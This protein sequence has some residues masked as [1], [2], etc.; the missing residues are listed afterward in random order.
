MSLQRC[1][2]WA[3][4]SKSAKSVGWCNLP[5]KYL[6]DVW[7][8]VCFMPAPFLLFFFCA[9]NYP[10]VV[11]FN[12]AVDLRW[13]NNKPGFGAYFTVCYLR[14]NCMQGLWL[15]VWKSSL[16][17]LSP[18]VS[19]EGLICAYVTLLQP[20][21]RFSVWLFLDRRNM[22]LFCS[23]FYYF[24]TGLFCQYLSQKWAIPNTEFAPKFNNDF[25]KTPMI[26]LKLRNL[27]Q[28]LRKFC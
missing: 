17:E 12:F 7:A 22:L 5:Q 14:H 6:V 13:K 4:N 28:E 27:C 3:A 24:D 8:R 18:K 2:E 11:L 1:S 16:G 15:F 9:C 26:L 10:R 20:G 19:G 23:S 21:A 25:V